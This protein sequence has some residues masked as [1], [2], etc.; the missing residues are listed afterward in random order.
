MLLGTVQV[1]TGLVFAVLIILVVKRFRNLTS[2][3][4]LFFATRFCSS[5]ETI[6]LLTISVIGVVIGGVVLSFWENYSILFF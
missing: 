3:K 5:I 1:E 2:L 4:P 6:Q